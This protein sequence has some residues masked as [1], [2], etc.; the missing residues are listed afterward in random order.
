[1]CDFVWITRWENDFNISEVSK[2]PEGALNSSLAY[3]VYQL[4][5]GSK[6]D[7]QLT[8]SMYIDGESTQLHLVSWVLNDTKY[9]DTL[10]I[11]KYPVGK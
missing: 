2:T 5:S 7:I 6:E 10:I 8:H 4:E 3:L 1:M 11:N 9:E